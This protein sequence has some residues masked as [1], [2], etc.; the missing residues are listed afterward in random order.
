MMKGYLTT[1]LSLSL[2]FFIAFLLFLMGYAIR[3]GGKVRF[4]T[5]V[6]IGMNSVL[7]EFHTGLHERYDLLYVD[8]SYLGKEPSVSNVEGR[9][10]FY[11]DENIQNF[12]E[13]N[14]WGTFDLESVTITS[15]QS[16]ALGK[17]NSMKYQA[18]QSVLDRG[19]EREEAE[20]MGYL[21]AIQNLD[22]KDVLGEWE[23]LQAKIA[24]MELPVILNEKGEWEEVPLANPADAV[25]GLA[26]SDV[27]FLAGI[28]CDQ[29]G[30]GHISQGDYISGRVPQNEISVEEKE[31]DDQLFLTYLFEKM[32]NF[33]R[34]RDGSLLQYQLEYIAV[35]KTSDYENL[36]AVVER[37]FRWRMAVN[38]NAVFHNGG[39]CG[40]ALAAAQEL[41]AVCLKEEFREPV[42]NSILYACAYLESIADVRCLMSGGR[43]KLSKEEWITGIEQVK[44]VSW[45]KSSPSQ[46][47]GLT[48]EQYL[49][50]LIML[51][52]EDNRNLRSMDIMEM[53]IRKLY[54][55]SGFC[56]DYCIER[57]CAEVRAS[58]SSGDS[59]FLKRNY[60][61]Y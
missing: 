56:M 37:L 49:A 19:T 54:G 31:A 47:A 18:V 60:G 32:G 44:E 7:A 45:K 5:V 23:A 61:Y 59:Y 29:I 46:Q 58:F 36:Q 33:G 53:D 42:A 28:D 1:F 15:Y 21:P 20:I 57:F 43:M 48:Y 34:V 27:L 2:S 55:N 40:E 51:L 16:A 35:G 3:N 12:H 41:P 6:D 24:G 13:G 9:L 8:A 52:D 30:T 4:E 26:Q 10:A 38:A 50:C 22:N 14:I 11:I 39:L 25:F 17:G